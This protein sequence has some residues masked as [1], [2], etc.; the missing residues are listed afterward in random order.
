MVPYPVSIPKAI[1]FILFA[2]KKNQVGRK[3]GHGSHAL[4]DNWD[5]TQIPKV[6]FFNGLHDGTLVFN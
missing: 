1:T 2:E 6:L 3:T 4:V 5:T